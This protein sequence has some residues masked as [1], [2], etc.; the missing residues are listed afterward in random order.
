[1][2]QKFVF[3][4]RV[5]LALNREKVWANANKLLRSG[6]HDKAISEFRR[7]LEDNASDVRSA[8]KMGDTFVKLGRRDEAI[9][10]YHQVATVHRKQ[11]FFLKAVAVYKQMLRVDANLVDVHLK[12]AEMYQQLGLS[13]DCMLHF[14]QVAIHYEKAGDFENTL[15]VL[16]RMTELAPDNIPSRIKLAELFAQQGQTAEAVS[17]FRSAGEYLKGQGRLDQYVQV[18]ERMVF[19]DPTLI[20]VI[21]ELATVYLR[22]GD[23]KLA[24]GKLQICF[25]SDPRNLETLTLIAEAFLSMEQMGKTLSVYKEMARIYDSGGQHDSAKRHW[26]RVLELDP[27]DTDAKHAL[28]LS[29]ELSSPNQK[30]PSAAEPSGEADEKEKIERLLTETTVYIKYGLKDKAVG[31]LKSILEMEADN[32]D[33]LESMREI[34]L[35][36]QDTAKAKETLQNLLAFAQQQSDP[37]ETKYRA[38]LE[39][40]EAREQ[41]SASVDLDA[42]DAN[43]L[44]LSTESHAV[45]DEHHTYE[46]DNG[47]SERSDNTQEEVIPSWAH[48]K[49]EPEGKEEADNPYYMSVPSDHKQATTG[50]YEDPLM[51]E[52][53]KEATERRKKDGAAASTSPQ[54]EGTPDA[55]DSSQDPAA[56]FFIEELQE[57][58]FF[59]EQGFLDEASEILLEIKEDVPNSPRVDRLLARIREAQ[60]GG[61]PN[62]AVDTPSIIEQVEEEMENNDDK[63]MLPDETGQVSVE[64]VLAQF[65]QGVAETVSH[66]DAE[67]HCNLGIAYREMGLLDDAISEFKLAVNSASKGAYAHH[68]IGLTLIAMSRYADALK[69]FDSALLYESMTHEEISGNEYQRGL[70]LEVQGQKAEALIAFKKAKE[71][72]VA[73]PDVDNKIQELSSGNAPEAPPPLRR[74][75]VDYL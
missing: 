31:H 56:E 17:E 9:D 20:D 60:S 42:E 46:M 12:L 68:M 15:S 47:P 3:C 23:P 54:D 73:M 51:A 55:D 24:L 5:A 61:E 16:R 53:A 57:A 40:E 28:G 6:K 67:T 63:T 21:R 14:Q 4:G 59:I 33:A 25:K 38:E 19:F 18:A 39:A 10:C 74:N 44:L 64:Q 75:K 72:G 22:R 37:R 32:L 36:D 7:L 13:S 58:E 35:E 29:D 34:Y 2:R 70:C 26:Q 62:A 8:L 45:T 65:R 41:D 52:L 1:L 66:D 50:V 49:P 11:G 48:Q 30:A 71:Y 69:H 43:E 27:L